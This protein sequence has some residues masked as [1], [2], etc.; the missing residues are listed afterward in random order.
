[1]VRVPAL[2]IQ[3]PQRNDPLLSEI[4][5]R[6]GGKYWIGLESTLGNNADPSTS[7]ARSIK[8]RDQ[9]NFLPGAPDREFQQ[10][11]MTLL[12]ALIAGALSLEWLTR[13]LSR[14]A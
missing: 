6:T 8:P 14:L 1:M 4:A 11:L 9:T 2:E 7:L 10:R 13:R 12:M 3:R 5:A